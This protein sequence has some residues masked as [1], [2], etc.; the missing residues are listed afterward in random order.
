MGNKIKRL[1]NPDQY[2][3]WR[4]GTKCDHSDSLQNYKV[5]KVRWIKVPMASYRVK[6]AAEIIRLIFT[7]L[8]LGTVSLFADGGFK[9]LSHECIEIE[10]TCRFCESTQRFT[11]EIMGVQNKLFTCGYYK[12]FNARS[13]YKPVSMTVDFAKERFNE[14]GD[15]FHFI[16]NNCYHWSK[17]LYHK[18][19]P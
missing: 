17:T 8:T 3:N 4:D 11:A 1:L 19:Q 13:T 14:M 2:G 15:S 16:Y 10:S 7:I 6:I 18:L 9:D 5:V 12:R